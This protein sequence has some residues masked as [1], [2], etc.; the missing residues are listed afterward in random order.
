[1]AFF[2]WDPSYS[3]NIKQFDSDHKKLIDLINMLHDAMKTGKAKDV[4]MS[5]F[6]DLESYTKTHFTNEERLME[7]HRYPGLVQQRTEHRL[8]IQRIAEQKS[9]FEKTNISTAMPI[10]NF[11]TDWL[12]NHILNSDKKY[13]AFLTQKGV[14]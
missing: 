3:V 14:H 5:I 13:S 8:F 9:I 11:L 12:K 1:M 7:Q 4:L 2:Q 10:M 6:S